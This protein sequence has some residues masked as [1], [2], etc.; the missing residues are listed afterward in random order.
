M[1]RKLGKGKAEWRR[2]VRGEEKQARETT[3][4]K[5]GSRGKEACDR[6]R[7]GTQS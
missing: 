5:G 6:S 3:E 2:G 7:R 1:G 4:G